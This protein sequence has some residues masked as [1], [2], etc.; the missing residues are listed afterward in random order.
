M[1]PLPALVN[2][3]PDIAS[4]IKSNANNGRNLPSY[5][6]LAL[7]APFPDIAFMNKD[8]TGCINQEAIGAINEAAI[9][10][11]KNP[12][13]CFF[14]SCFTVSV[15][16]AIKRPGFSSDF[17]ILMISSTS[18]FEMNKVNPFSALTAAL[19][20]FQIYLIQKK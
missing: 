20:F 9:I 12:P 19:F 18:S 1:Y 13:S 4:V 5:P 8:A 10:A 16:P 17:T 15:V 7:M 6:I 3:F 11:P 2:P 14:I